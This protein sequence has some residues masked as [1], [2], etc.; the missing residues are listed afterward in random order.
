M[1]PGIQDS[2]NLNFTIEY[3]QI[4]G[5]IIILDVANIGSVYALE[6]LILVTPMNCCTLLASYIWLN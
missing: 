2:Q 3:K 5:E 1:S 4:K 6:C